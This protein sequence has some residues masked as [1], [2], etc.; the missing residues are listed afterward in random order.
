MSAILLAVACAGAEDPVTPDDDTVLSGVSVAASV[1]E[2]DGTA[3][4]GSRVKRMSVDVTLTN[5]TSSSIE[6]SYPAGCPTRFRLYRESDDALVYDQT[7]LPCSVSTT[8]SLT[9]AP[10]Q[11]R[12]LSSGGRFPWEISGDSLAPGNY[13]VTG[14]LRITGEEPIEL[15]AGTYRLPLCSTVSNA[16]VCN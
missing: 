3:G 12:T 11:A 9:L 16:T 10:F 13:R 7:A 14:V 5:T 4:T 8:A 15:E 2:V 6:Y 1:I